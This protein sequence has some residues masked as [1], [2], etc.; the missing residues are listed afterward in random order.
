MCYRHDINNVK[1]AFNIGFTQKH[2]NDH[3]SVN[4]W[5]EELN[6][7][8]EDSPVLLYK[9]QGVK[10]PHDTP[11][12]ARSDFILCMQTVTQRRFMLQFGC[13]NIVCLDSTHGTTQ[14]GLVLVTVM[15]LDGIGEGNPVAFMI[16]NREDEAVLTAF[17]QSIKSR[18]PQ[19]DSYHASHLMTDDA[20]QYYNA[21]I[22]VFGPADKLLCTWHI[23]KTW[24]RAVKQHVQERENQVEIYH[25]LRCL[26][27]E[28]NVDDFKCCLSAFMQ[29]VDN[30]A[31]SFASY[32]AAYCSR[33]TEWAYC[34]RVGTQANT[35][36]YVESFHN[37]LKTCYLE[38]KVNRRVDNLISVLMRIARDK[39]FERLIKVEKHSHSK[40]L[41]EINKR[42]VIVVDA[43][44][45]EN[46][47][48]WRIPSQS[49]ELQYLV[50]P[51]KEVCACKLHCSTCQCCPHMYDCSC[52]DFAVH[53]TVCK[54]VHTVHH[55]RAAVLNMEP[56]AAADDDAPV[57][58]TTSD[59][60]E[61]IPQ[62]MESESVPESSSASRE[63]DISRARLLV[64]MQCQQ[65]TTVASTCDDT[66][67]LGPTVCTEACADS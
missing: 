65:L 36:M 43:L 51:A 29:H 63:A 57:D 32:F 20:S 49:T 44:P 62:P 9:G 64:H 28:L 61:D 23:D 55:L 34:Y 13:G 2:V 10:W 54:H 59:A 1:A 60:A 5:V 46:E 31:P 56:V 4:A 53:A 42:H 40:K 67:A 17:F 16:S 3:K 7:M 18:L 38:R 50:V 45:S 12:L 33:T 52:V 24:R 11:R 27:Q 21:W 30:V 15:V 37:V 47:G 19:A 41:Q 8:N 25:M 39:V 48:G 58:N 26:L 6:A 14:Y 35:N 22:A 66:E